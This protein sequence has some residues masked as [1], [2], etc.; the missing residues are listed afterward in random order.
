M[1]RNVHQ[2]S[3]RRFGRLFGAGAALVAAR[4]FVSLAG[5][6]H[7]DADVIGKGS[8]SLSKTASPI[9]RLSANENPYGPSALALK[10]MTECFDVACRYP[11]EQVDLLVETLAKINNVSRDQVLL[12]AGSGEILKLAAAAFTGPVT[13]GPNR[14]VELAPRSRG[15]VMPA[16]MAGRGKMIVADPTVLSRM[17]V[18]E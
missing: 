2:I 10:A 17:N 11:D 18:P 9:V 4:P 16:F 1:K 7:N 3:R 13:M 12:G 5:S 6:V 14:P 8:R 15:G